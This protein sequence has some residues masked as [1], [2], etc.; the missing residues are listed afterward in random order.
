MLY[1]FMPYSFMLCSK[2]M[3][4]MLQFSAVFDSANVLCVLSDQEGL[5]APDTWSGLEVCE[6]RSKERTHQKGSS[7]VYCKTVNTW[8]KCEML[9][10]M[11]H[12]HSF[13]LFL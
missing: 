11:Q 6:V 10:I 13:R 9:Y 4:V 12:V 5:H 1:S 2:T 8:T 7:Q 3:V